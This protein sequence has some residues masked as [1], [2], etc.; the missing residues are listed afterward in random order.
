VYETLKD[1]ETRW[2]AI[3]GWLVNIATAGIIL[4]FSVIVFGG[5]VVL[6]LFGGNK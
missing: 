3:H 5:L 1:E 4:L 6:F 2:E